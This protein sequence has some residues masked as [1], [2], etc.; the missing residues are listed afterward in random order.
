[1]YTSKESVRQLKIEMVK[2]IDV[3]TIPNVNEILR[4]FVHADSFCVYS[5]YKNQSYAC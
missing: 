1:M 3:L 4:I 2:N 5:N